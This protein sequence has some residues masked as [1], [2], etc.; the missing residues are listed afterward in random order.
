MSELEQPRMT[1]ESASMKPQPKAAQKLKDL[2]LSNKKKGQ[3]KEKPHQ[4]K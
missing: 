3:E 1:L 2:S 4:A